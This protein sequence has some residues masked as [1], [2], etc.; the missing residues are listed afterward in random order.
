MI[1]GCLT[2]AADAARVVYLRD[3]AETGPDADQNPPLTKRQP[4]AR[5]KPWCG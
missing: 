1:Q 2:S 4:R 3:L 5:G